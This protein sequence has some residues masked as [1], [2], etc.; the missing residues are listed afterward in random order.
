MAKAAA[1]KRCVDE[2]VRDGL[3][4]GIGTGSTVA[5]LIDNII[6]KYTNS[7]LK[8]IICV[9]TSI[10]TKHRLMLANVPTTELTQCPQLDICID[11]ADEVDSH[12]NCIKGGGGALM[13]EK[14]IFEQMNK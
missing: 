14:V 7:S 4:L 11:G 1:A 10:E 12:L 9:P 3:K 6:E 5:F 2:C 13:M 8:N